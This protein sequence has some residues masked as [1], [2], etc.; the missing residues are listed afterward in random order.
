MLINTSVGPSAAMSI[1]AIYFAF[2]VDT[3]L[4]IWGK[5]KSAPRIFWPKNERKQKN[6][7]DD[8]TYSNSLILHILI[9]NCHV[10]LSKY[11]T[12]ILTAD[13]AP[14]GDSPLKHQAAIS[15]NV[16]ELEKGGLNEQPSNDI[17]GRVR[18]VR[19]FK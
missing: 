11:C 12:V 7:H 17:M 13:I 1:P 14:H 10:L 8:G 4:Y 5:L 19:V 16:S 2:H 15:K 9:Q 3:A 18:R 6:K